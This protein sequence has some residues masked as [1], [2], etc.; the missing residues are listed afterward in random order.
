MARTCRSGRAI[1]RSKKCWLCCRIR[2]WQIP[3]MIEY[4]YKGADTV[5]EVRKSYEFMKQALA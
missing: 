2:Q 4:E 5:E 3:A 1:R